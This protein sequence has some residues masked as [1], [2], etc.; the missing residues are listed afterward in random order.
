MKLSMRSTLKRHHLEAELAIRKEQVKNFIVASRAG[1]FSKDRL[2][3]SCVG[4]FHIETPLV[5]SGHLPLCRLANSRSKEA[6]LP[7][8][9]HE[10]YAQVEK[11]VV[12]APWG[13]RARVGRSIA[14]ASPPSQ[15]HVFR[16]WGRYLLATVL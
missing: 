5:D 4:N 1:Y 11:Q 6:S 10:T 7:D 15:Y 16:L 2:G 12:S 8:A 3:R 9:G 14:A 13:A